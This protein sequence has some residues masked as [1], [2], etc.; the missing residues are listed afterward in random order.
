[1][2]ESAGSFV[3]EDDFGVDW[4]LVE[5]P[6]AVMASA[7]CFV[8]EDEDGA[9]PPLLLLPVLPD[10]ADLPEA[11]AGLLLEDESSLLG[12]DYIWHWHWQ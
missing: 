5:A 6:V 4:R 11:W 10:R 8:E 1:M 9:F 2:L 3:E 12:L 7:G